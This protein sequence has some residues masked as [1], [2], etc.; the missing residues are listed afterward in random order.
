MKA[1]AL[2]V[3]ILAMV[4]M[5]GAMVSHA[6]SP[7]Q[8]AWG[9][10]RSGMGDKSTERRTRTVRMLRFLPGDPEALEMA[11]KALNDEK[12][13]VRAA[14]VTALGQMGSTPSIP[15]LKNALSDKDASVVLAAA[16]ALR[17]LKDPTAYEVYYEVLAGERKP[18]K[19]LVA[20]GIET[21][22]DRKKMA[23][24]GFEEGV[25]FIP[26]AGEGYAAV[27]ALAKDDTSPV[28]AAA[29]KILTDDPDARSGQA[30]VGA[31][32]D[33]S[34]IVRAAAL[35]AIGS[36]GDFQLLNGVVSAMLDKNEVVRYTAA[37]VV[38]RLTT[39]AQPIAKEKKK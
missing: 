15:E 27:R 32:S 18:S 1:L 6:Q 28:R 2:E 36:R 5:A 13:E 19:G 9:I 30:L 7:Q 34:W 29:A 8:Q 37:A 33:K 11:Q 16:H 25:G 12:A 17:A 14:A 23:E 21:L 35:D 24:F 38:I 26:F 22:K 20:Q 3:W 10:L 39:L 31:V 4:V